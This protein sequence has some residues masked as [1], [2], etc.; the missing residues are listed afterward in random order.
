[1]LAP[2]ADRRLHSRK[3][4]EAAKKLDALQ[5]TAVTAVAAVAA[6]TSVTSDG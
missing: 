1:L 4:S 6:V 3:G 2:T 5:V